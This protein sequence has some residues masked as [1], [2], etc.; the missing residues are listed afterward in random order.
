MQPTAH[1]AAFYYEVYKTA[2]QHK[3]SGFWRRMQKY[4]KM[5]KGV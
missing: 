2:H 5:A 3:R 1:I 4:L